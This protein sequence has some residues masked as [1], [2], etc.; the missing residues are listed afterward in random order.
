MPPGRH[1]SSGVPIDTF[2]LSGREQPKLKTEAVGIPLAVFTG[3][4]FPVDLT[5]ISPRATEATVELAAEG[6]V[7]GSH[8]VALEAGENRVRIR[9]SLNAAGAIDISGKIEAAG[10]GESRFENAVAVR[11]PQSVVGFR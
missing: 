2:A 1:S 6:K 4:R 9:T 10:L 8:R 3:E 5:I 11:R 7:I